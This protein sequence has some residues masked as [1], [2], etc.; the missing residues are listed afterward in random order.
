MDS[1]SNRVPCN[2]RLDR[3]IPVHIDCL[4]VGSNTERRKGSVE[5]DGA[6]WKG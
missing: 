2:R 6:A 3:Q 4:S 1:K 5:E